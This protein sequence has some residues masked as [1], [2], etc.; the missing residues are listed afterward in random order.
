MVIL[1]RA[2]ARC[3]PDLNYCNSVSA[4]NVKCKSPRVVKLCARACKSSVGREKYYLRAIAKHNG[5]YCA[6][7]KRE[8]AGARLCNVQTIDCGSATSLG[9][10][11]AR[12]TMRG[13][14]NSLPFTIVSLTFTPLYSLCASDSHVTSK[15]RQQYLQNI[16]TKYFVFLSFTA[17]L[18]K[19]PDYFM[20]DASV[21]PLSLCSEYKTQ[22]EKKKKQKQLH[23]SRCNSKTFVL[24]YTRLIKLIIICI[25]LTKQSYVFNGGN[26]EYVFTCN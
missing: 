1:S 3:Y 19:I 4:A 21:I 20:M 24:F 23:K 18:W 25:V 14:R 7:P 12:N 17:A 6:H 8:L 15:R 22:F 16:Y 5:N 13:H 26:L 11:I 10:T 9:N 2:S